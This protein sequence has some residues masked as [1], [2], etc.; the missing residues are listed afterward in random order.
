MV[1]LIIMKSNGK[2]D[3]WDYIEVDALDIG[4]V[5]RV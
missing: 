1:K 4:K 2:V 5:S 3:P